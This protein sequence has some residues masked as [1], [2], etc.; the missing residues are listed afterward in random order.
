V[1]WL[2]LHNTDPGLR[3]ATLRV[4]F[5]LASSENII[6]RVQDSESDKHSS[7]LKY[8]IDGGWTKVL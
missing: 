2:R 8:R 6:P 1:V 3:N 5:F 4:G 7:L